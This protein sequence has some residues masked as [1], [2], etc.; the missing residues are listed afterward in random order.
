MSVHDVTAHDVT[1]EPARP[2]FHPSASSPRDP[3]TLRGLR[4]LL[5]RVHF[6][7]GLLV[8]PFILVAALTGLAYT[9]VPQL[10]EIAYGDRLHVS[11]VGDERLPVIEQVGAAQQSVPG[12][13]VSSVLLPEDA[14]DT[15]QV[16][17]ADP[18]LDND[19][20]RTVYVNPYTG[21]VQGE[22]VTWF[23]STPLTTWRDDL[24]RN[25]H[26]GDVGRHYSEI[27]ASWL[28]VL[29][30]SGIVL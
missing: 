25:L 1:A 7:A 24:H 2:E 10:D 22:L 5:T 9:L 4:A 11:E 17:F 28:W 21:E 26:L 15:T 29:A 27:A 13:G 6:Y 18:S 12:L 3:G 16:V 20:E 30:L 23:G 14:A 8:G 19:R